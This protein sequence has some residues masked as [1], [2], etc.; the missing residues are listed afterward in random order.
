MEWLD[1]EALVVR[2]KRR[3]VEWANQ[4][5]DDG[6]KITLEEARSHSVIFLI[7][8]DSGPA[9]VT[10][11]VDVYWQELFE[12]MLAAW[13]E[14]EGDW[15]ANRTAHL[16]RDWF[17]VEFIEQ[18]MDADEDLPLALA[19]ADVPE[20]LDDPADDETDAEDEVEDVLN[21]CAWCRAE[22]PPEQQHLALGLQYD[23]PEKLA[24]LHGMIFPYQLAEKEII[25]FIP[26]ADSD[27]WRAGQHI[28]FACCSDDCVMH[29][30]EA[31]ERRSSA[32]LS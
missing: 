3:Y 26:A 8:A 7:A 17:D 24:P 31:I 13:S 6:P 29:L 12:E 19:D 18:V 11:I 21:L 9:D 14:D 22:I 25:G 32:H 10:S 4:N 16:F 5:R 23:Q 2:P 15:P 28:V 30:R 27:A 20:A 1:R